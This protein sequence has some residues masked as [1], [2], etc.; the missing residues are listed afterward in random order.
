MAIAIGTVNAE[1]VYVRDVIYVPL[2]EGQSSEDRVL[3]NGLRSGTRLERL[4]KNTETGNSLV[5]TENGMEGWIPNQYL[6]RQPIAADLLNEA[7]QRLKVINQEYELALLRIEELE[8]ILTQKNL[9][10]KALNARN[11]EISGELETN[12]QLSA[13]A[14]EIDEGNSQLL[15]EQES[16]IANLGASNSAFRVLQDESKQLWFLYGASSVALSMLIGFWVARR[17]YR[18]SKSGGW[19]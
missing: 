1:V 15:I 18:D 2:R 13:K 14:T 3:H 9:R 12:T 19:S 10:E 6:I 7:K 5:R 17:I 11:L 16:Q 4:T 8:D